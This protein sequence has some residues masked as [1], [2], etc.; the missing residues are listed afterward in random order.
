MP[1]KIKKSAGYLFLTMALV[2]SAKAHSQPAIPKL[3]FEE[4]SPWLHR[5]N[6]TTYVINF[7]A[8]WC[9]PC[10]KELP[11]FEEINE[12]M[13]KEKVRV[14]LVSLDFPQQ[15][16]TSLLPFVKRKGLK[17]KV[18]YLDDG[19]ANFWIPKVDPDW[20]GAI[21]ATLIYKGKKRK[22]YEKSFTKEQLLKAIEKVGGV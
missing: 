18:L 2:L 6:D 10:I 11:H 12:S 7:W 21:P 17:S 9:S 19:K 3:S 5:N 1:G 16:D 15:Y 13:G 14:I 8:T 20:T 22:F 4:L